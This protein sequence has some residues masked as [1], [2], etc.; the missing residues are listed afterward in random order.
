[1]EIENSSE[2][3]QEIKELITWVNELLKVYKLL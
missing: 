1:M 2:R 3:D